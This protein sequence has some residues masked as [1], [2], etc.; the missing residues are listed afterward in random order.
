MTTTRNKIDYSGRTVDLLLLK[1]VLGVPVEMKRVDLDASGDPMIVTGVEKLVQR[2]AILFINAAGSTMFRPDHG[3]S[4]VHDVASGK[5]YSTATLETAAAEANTIAMSS[6]LAA[7]QE[8]DGVPDDERLAGAEV[9]NVEFSPER[10]EARVSVRLTTAA[11]D[12]YTYIIPVGVGV[13]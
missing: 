2:Y 7:D 11:G 10:S 5:V 1:T 12:S 13:H 4:V 8:D 3:T 6:I 9:E